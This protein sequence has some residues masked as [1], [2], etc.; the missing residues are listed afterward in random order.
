MKVELQRLESSI[1]V[2]TS[3]ETGEDMEADEDLF[4]HSRLTREYQR[5]GEFDWQSFLKRA[6]NRAREEVYKN[7]VYS[8]ES[9]RPRQDE[10]LYEIGCKVRFLPLWTK[11]PNDILIAWQG[12]GS[13]IQ[14]DAILNLKSDRRK[15]IGICCVCP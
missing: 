10:K 15:R 6:E 7:D 8:V 1:S 13:G 5:T 2:L 3:S 9:R 4:S 11:K 14:G 12:R